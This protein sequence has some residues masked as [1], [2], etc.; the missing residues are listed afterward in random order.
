MSSKPT[1]TEKTESRQDNCTDSTSLK[2]VFTPGWPL[3][4]HIL[5]REKGV[6]LRKIADIKHIN[7]LLCAH[8]IF[9]HA[10]GH[11]IPSPA[12]TVCTIELIITSHNLSGQEVDTATCEC[13][14]VLTIL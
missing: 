3:M 4:I 5:R 8:F 6:H 2:F 14:E 7:D 11:M 1:K 12:F 9:I 13:Q 10:M